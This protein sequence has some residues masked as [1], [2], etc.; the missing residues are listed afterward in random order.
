MLCSLL[1]YFNHFWNK[2]CNLP[3]L[4]ICSSQLPLLMFLAS[5]WYQK[6]KIALRMSLQ[7]K[8]WLIIILKGFIKQPVTKQ[9]PTF[10]YFSFLIKCY[11]SFFFSCLIKVYPKFEKLI[12]FHRQ[13]FLV[14]KNKDNLRMFCQKLIVSNVI[15]AFL[16]H[17][18]T[19]IAFVG[20]PW[21]PT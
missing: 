7:N 16:D 21:W 20:Q 3:S 2:Y 12:R 14:Y 10:L 19:K 13:A 11:M 9:S 6:A 1:N 4:A 18:K 15:L 17:L 5:Y 8:K